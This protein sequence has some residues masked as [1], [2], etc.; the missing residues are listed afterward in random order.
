MSRSNFQFSSLPRNALKNLSKK[1]GK[2][3]SGRGDDTKP[4]VDG[5]KHLSLSQRKLS[6]RPYSYVN[7]ALSAIMR[8]ESPNSC[9]R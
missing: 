4:A 5:E 9:V 6:E 2:S 8:Q 7:G 3:P 1:F